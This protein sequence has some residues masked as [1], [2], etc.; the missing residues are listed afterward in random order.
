MVFLVSRQGLSAR[1]V[2][3]VE[4]MTY[5]RIFKSEKIEFFVL[6]NAWKQNLNYSLTQQHA[7][8]S[9]GLFFLSCGND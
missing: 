6:I 8:P 9:M 2:L 5:F 4:S 3:V 7:K 1:S